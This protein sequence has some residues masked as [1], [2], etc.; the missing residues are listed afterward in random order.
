MNLEELQ[1][2]LEE[3]VWW[4]EEHTPDERA[5]RVWNLEAEIALAKAKALHEFTSE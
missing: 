5:E 3:A 4:R 1:A 2:R